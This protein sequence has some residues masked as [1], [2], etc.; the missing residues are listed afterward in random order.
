MHNTSANLLGSA[1]AEAAHAM[2]QRAFIATA[3]YQTLRYTVD[4]NYAVDWRGTGKSAIFQ[5]LCSDFKEDTR[6]VLLKEE[7]QDYEMHEYCLEQ[8]AA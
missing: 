8:K 3:D 7:P 5:L 4:F 6:V 1:Q 2:L